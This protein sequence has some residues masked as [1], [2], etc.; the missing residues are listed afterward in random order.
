TRSV[1][2][3][4]NILSTFQQKDG[5]ILVLTSMYQYRI[6]RFGSSM[7]IKDTSIIHVLGIINDEV[8]VAQ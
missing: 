6:D 7:S 3:I 1:P 2:I 4:G 8:Y 5:A